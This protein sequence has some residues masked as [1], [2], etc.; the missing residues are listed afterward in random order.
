MGKD[1]QDTTA[2]AAIVCE[3]H[4]LSG[5]DIA[6]GR[7]EHGVNEGLQKWSMTAIRAC[8]CTVRWRPATES[9]RPRF[10]PISPYAPL[11]CSWMVWQSLAEFGRKLRNS[12]LVRRCRVKKPMPKASMRP[13]TA[14]VVK[15]PPKDPLALG[16]VPRPESS[17][18]LGALLARDLVVDLQVEGSPVWRSWHGEATVAKRQ[19][20]HTA[21]GEWLWNY[22][23]LVAE[24]RSLSRNRARVNLP[25]AA[26][27]RRRGC[28]RPRARCSSACSTF[29]RCGRSLRLGTSNA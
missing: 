16:A 26:A 20:C 21:E 2:T 22:R 7:Y 9:H 4:T 18:G 27:Q 15:A 23:S 10:S 11:P 3:E 24:M 12:F 29:W 5:G 13:S 6:S 17:Y 19:Q 28:M 8:S 25:G 14:C 1:C